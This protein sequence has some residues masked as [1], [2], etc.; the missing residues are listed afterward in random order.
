[1]LVEQLTISPSAPACRMAASRSAAGLK[2]CCRTT[3]SVTPASAQ[4][5]TSA[6]RAGRN[7][8]RLL[9]QDVLAGLGELSCDLEMRV[10]RGEDGDRCDAAVFE[11]A[12]EAA[13]G[14]EREAGRERLSPPRAWAHGMGDLDPVLRDRAGSW[15]AASRPCRGRRGRCGGGSCRGSRA[16]LPVCL[17]QSPQR[18]HAERSSPTPPGF[19]RTCSS[20][21]ERARRSCCTT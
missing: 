19:R 20:P 16:A 6:R 7:I 14:G 18:G 21:K 2:R 17:P 9:E 4:A 5:A 12:A 8:E 15:R 1:M 13:R 10:G 11:D 3:P